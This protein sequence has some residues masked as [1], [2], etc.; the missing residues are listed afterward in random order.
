[1]TL[2]IFRLLNV[3]F[4]L[5]LV[6]VA[7]CLCFPS[8][9][10]RCRLWVLLLSTLFLSLLINSSECLAG[11]RE[12]KLLYKKKKVCEEVELVFLTLCDAFQNSKTVSSL[13]Y[14]D[15]EASDDDGWR[16]EISWKLWKIISRK[17]SSC[18]F[19]TTEGSAVLRS[20]LQ[21]R[22]TTEMRNEMRWG[23]E[24]RDTLEWFINEKTQGEAS[25]KKQTCNDG[26]SAT[27]TINWILTWAAKHKAMRHLI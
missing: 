6:V 22:L 24:A 16:N 17:A 3:A 10:C 15:A 14:D 25:S 2:I 27:E 5:L 20:S 23:G 12:M 19:L 4:C 8:S 1:M 13:I 26:A 18:T 21:S 9:S 7:A 11:S